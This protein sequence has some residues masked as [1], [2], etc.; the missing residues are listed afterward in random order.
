MARM[1]WATLHLQSRTWTDGC[2]FSGVGA[3]AP[4]FLECN[5]SRH[6]MQREDLLHSKFH[7]PRVKWGVGDN[8]HGFTP[9]EIFLLES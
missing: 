9:L 6:Y 7:E 3:L 4:L 2:C 5:V 1:Y 8:T